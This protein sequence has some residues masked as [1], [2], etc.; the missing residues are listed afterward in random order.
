MVGIGWSLAV[1]F[2][3]RQT[4]K[5][6][7]RCADQPAWHRQEDTFMYNG[8]QELVPIDSAAATK[9]EGA[10]VPSV[11]GHEKP[12]KDGEGRG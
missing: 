3:S 6:L 9:M 7:P 8:G 11:S 2:I 12:R 10:T 4:D 1:P 5:G